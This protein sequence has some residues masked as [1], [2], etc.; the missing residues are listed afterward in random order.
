MPRGKNLRPLLLLRAATDEQLLGLAQG[1]STDAF[2]EIVARFRPR[3]TRYCAG[4]TRAERVDD[5]V[6]QTFMN[7][8]L[9]LGRGAA[10]RELRPWLYGIA[11]NAAID[12][13]RLARGEVVE[14][15][16]EL[17]GGAD[18][19]VVAAARGE[20]D[21]VLRAVS[22]LPERQR[23]ALLETAVH[24]KSTES[25]ADEMGMSGGALRQLVHR[26]RTS[27]RGMVASF[28]PGPAVSWFAQ[29]SSEE[30]TRR[31]AVLVSGA[32]QGAT[33]AALAATATV[34]S[35]G[36]IGT[37]GLGGLD[38]SAGKRS[39]VAPTRSSQESRP[40]ASASGGAAKSPLTPAS[41][42]TLPLPGGAATGTTTTS[43]SSGDITP[44][45]TRRPSQS[46]TRDAGGG[47]DGERP[48]RH[49]SRGRSV[50]PSRDGDSTSRE[51]TRPS[52]DR[53]DSSPAAD[54]RSPQ[55]LA[56]T[57]HPSSDRPRRSGGG[58]GG[59][60]SG[61]DEGSGHGDD[62]HAAPS[63]TATP[64]PTSSA[65][66]ESPDVSSSQQPTAPADTTSGSGPSEESEPQA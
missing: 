27:V 39:A 22:E 62:D 1:G 4:L 52:G 47:A 29:A 8:W 15:S 31:L 20:I 34:A 32:G 63:P 11:R 2:D 40:V 21:D 46:N 60:A 18:P 7:A 33:A 43:G 30:G 58:R 38:D 36:A 37:A 23:T 56:A 54:S 17:A 16:P 61:S 51:F 53:G 44:A 45:A 25:V 14:L 5:A 9:A 48:A 57:S 10:V 42:V 65:Q 64:A 55:A 50:D 24:G 28:L 35:V 66:P 49:R 19:A 3:L 6:Q 12:Q 13:L 59:P 41:L 26:A